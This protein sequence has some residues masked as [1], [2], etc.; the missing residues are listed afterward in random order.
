MRRNL[1]GVVALLV[2]AM[3]FAGVTPT[4]A[5]QIILDG[6]TDPAYINI[7]QC[8][9]TANGI[10]DDPMNVDLTW[11]LAFAEGG[12]LTPGG[13]YK[14]FVTKRSPDSTGEQSLSCEQSTQGSD[15]VH[16]AVGSDD[17][18]IAVN[19]DNDPMISSVAVS[20]HDIAVA[21]ATVNGSATPCPSPNTLPTTVY[22]CVEWA[23]SVGGTPAGRATAQLTLDL[24]APAVAPVL[25]NVGVGDTRLYPSWTGIADTGATYKAYADAAGGTSPAKSSDEAAA[26]SSTITGLTNGVVYNVT[27]RGFDP[28]GNPSPASAALQGT[29]ETVSDFW[30]EYRSRGGKETGGC[31]SGAA[32]ILALLGAAVAPLVTRRRKS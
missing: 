25:K 2:P 29:P 4:T 5:G 31:S 30:D 16:A 12:A 1:L 18:T 27:V 15:L 19:G 6:S 28:A 21:H 26:T 20:R 24:T 3:G 7:A 9:G 10:H 8:G 13:T 14:L 32:G 17:G 23:A 22:L 11:K